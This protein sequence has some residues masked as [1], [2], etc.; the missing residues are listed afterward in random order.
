MKRTN[1][2]HAK[3]MYT[4]NRRRRRPSIRGASSSGAAPSNSIVGLRASSGRS[5]DSPSPKFRSIAMSDRR[6]N[7]WV[8]ECVQRVDDGID[9]D[10]R[11]ADEEHDTLHGDE[12][13]GQDRLD[14]Q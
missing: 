7:A 12:V 14:E 2:I 10:V 9:Q 8:E 5:P 6:P 11:D 3:A 13:L 1:A 4:P